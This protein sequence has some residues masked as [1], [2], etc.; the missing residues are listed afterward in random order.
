[1]EIL[2]HEGNDLKIAFFWSRM[3]RPVRDQKGYSKLI[4]SLR[5]C[6]TKMLLCD[7]VTY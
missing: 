5:L 6:V 2:L 1:M 3:G 4:F 7:Q